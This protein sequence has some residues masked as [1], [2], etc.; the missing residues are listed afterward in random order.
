[1]RSGRRDIVAKVGAPISINAKLDPI[2]VVVVKEKATEKQDPNEYPPMKNDKTVTPIPVS[3]ST[4][5]YQKWWFW[6]AAGVVVVG[7]VTAVLLAV[8]SDSGGDS[9]GL[10]ISLD[11]AQVENDAIFRNQ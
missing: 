3:A 7:A 11:P 4:P 2:K 6:T 5:I 8:N 9:G 10:L 1:M